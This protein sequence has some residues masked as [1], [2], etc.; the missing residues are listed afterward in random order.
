MTAVFLV[1]WHYASARVLISRSM[2]NCLVDQTSTAKISFHAELA[3]RF[4][5]ERKATFFHF[6]TASEL[7]IPR[8][9]PVPSSRISSALFGL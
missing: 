8:V 4:E 6:F 3:M 5:N 7:K 1:R 9:F 2:L